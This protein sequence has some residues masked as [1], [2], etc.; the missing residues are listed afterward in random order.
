MT[1]AL[2]TALGAAAQG[3]SWQTATEVNNGQ[4][5]NSQLSDTKGPDW[6]KIVVP[7]E[8]IVKVSV[9]TEQSLRAG[10]IYV[11]ALGAD[12]ELH[13]HGQ[14]DMD[15]Y[16]SGDLVV[17]EIPDMAPGTYYIQQNHYGGYGGYQLKYEFIANTHGADPEPNNEWTAGSLL[18]SGQTVEGRLGYYYFNDQDKVDWY[19][20]EV[21]DE[22]MVRFSMKTETTLRAGNI[23]VYALGADGELHSHGQRDMD[24]YGSGDLVVLEIPDMAPG[25]YYIQQNHYGGYGGYQLKYEFIA[26]THGA[27]PEPNNEWTA[28]SLLTSG[29]TV[30]GRLGYYY[31]NDQDKVDWYKIEVPDE[32]M[33]RFSVKTELTLRADNLFVYAMGTDGELYSHGQ[34]DMDNYGNDTTVVLEIVDM[35]PGTY[36]VRQNHYRGYGGYRLKYEFEPNLFGSDS[37]DNDTYD[38]AIQLES[39]V[40]QNGRLGYY[41]HDDQD[42]ADWYKIEVPQASSALFSLMTQTT[43]RAGN[44]IV[45]ALGSDG[46]L[47]SH[48]Q[49]DMDNYSKDTTL[50]LEIPDLAPGTYYIMQGRYRGYGGYR[51]NYQLQPN[52]FARNHYV[53]NTF[54]KRIALEEGKTVYNT[55]GYYYHNDMNTEGWYDLGMMNGRQ[56][57]VT[58]C[59]DLSH[60]LNIGVVNLYRYEGNREDG[61]PILTSVASQRLER[62][63]GTISFIDKESTP[64]HYVVQVPRYSGYGGYSIVFG[65]AQEEGQSSVSTEIAVMTGGRSTVRKGVPCENTITISNL[66]DQPSEFFM[67]AVEPT[68]DVKII[69]FRMPVGYGS[70]YIPAD[71]VTIEGDNMCLFFV[72]RMNPWESYTF[73][74]IS[75]GV[76]DIAYAPQHM[77]VMANGSRRIIIAGT[78]VTVAA[79]GTFVKGAAISLAVGAAVDWVSK[80]AGDAIFPADS[81]EA[82]QYANLMGSTVQ[83]LGIKSSWDSP[84]VYTAKS[85]SGTAAMEYVK[86]VGGVN[87]KTGT[88]IDAV[89]YAVTALTNI[90]PNLRRKIWYWIY[91]DLGYFGN[92]PV[93]VLD[94]K[95]AVTDVV[96]SWD[97]NEMIGPQGFGDKHYIGETQTV[98]YR[99]LFENKAEAGAPA[100]RVRISDELDANVFDVSS[101]QFGETSHSGV[102]YNW[103]MTREGNKLS[104]DIEGIELPP[105]VN[106]PEGEGFVSFSV[107]LKPGLAS[108]TEL[109]NKATIIFDKNFPI[110]TNE[111]VNTLD[112]VA[113]VTTMVSAHKLDTDTV[114]VTC[115]SADAESGVSCFL[116]FAAK[117]GGDYQYIGQYYQPT[118]DCPV[119]GNGLDYTFYVLALDEVGNIEQVTP[120]AIQTGIQTVRSGANP[121]AGLKVYTLD[122]RYVGNSL[123]QLAKGVYV[124]NGRKYVVK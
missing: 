101:V 14:R 74:M 44:M 43:L 98:N 58:V 106:A 38:K 53:N 94:G 17:L 112:L 64:S 79:I 29:Q 115:R 77:E 13:S 91:K 105:N 93:D 63:E 2:L 25:T 37:P 71:S 84:T 23:Y 19:K 113:P 18:T 72:P 121:L 100:Y 87:P 60:S 110:E 1:L 118:M 78:V 51:L 39:G 34:R 88:I 104:W 83:D 31:F 80:K 109:K 40:T 7:D 119:E 26:N 32:G 62:S 15:S 30:E 117:A 120:T 76:G 92:D 124:I 114:R 24:S 36:Y 96:A 33:V 67:L 85:V 107:N 47:Y 54:D 86:K 95:K 57:D 6:Y 123:Q 103:K 56:I 9:A 5:V 10:N 8:G 28:G 116:L 35:A 41:Y 48:G 108:G 3:D 89:G 45:Y 46:E 90:I 52:T 16:G 42:N 4:T 27:D 11:Y 55:L 12:G 66:S 68:D 61:S 122:G 65:H 69:G 102:G 81:E 59:P 50:V 21:P 20:I 70:Q 111:F 73:T 22:G 82:R 97:P 99:I 49:R 75:E